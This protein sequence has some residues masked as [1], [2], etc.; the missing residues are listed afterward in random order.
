MKNHINAFSAPCS[1][2]GACVSACPK[3]A[4]KVSL[5]KEGVYTATVDESRCV[6]CGQ[7]KTVCMRLDTSSCLPLSSGTIVAAQSSNA[8]TVKKCT[9][10]GIAYE[11]SKYAFKNGMGILG[12]IYDY[13]TS[14]AVSCI[15]KTEE[16]IERFRGSKYIQSYTADAFR[17][18]LAEMK[19]DSTR[20]YLA[21][22][23]PCQIYGLAKLLE[24]HHMR[25]RAILVDLFCH[26]VPS[27]RVWDQYL[28]SLKAQLGTNRLTEVVFRDKSIGWH[29]FVIK[30]QSDKGEYKEASE[31]DLFY[32]AFFDNVLFSEACFDCAVRKAVSKADLRL[33]DYWGK[34]YQH[35]EDGISAVLLCT[36]RGKAFLEQIKDQ[37][38]C[39][40]AGSVD[41][42]MASQSVHIY[43]TKTYRQNA[44]F[45]LQQGKSL[46]KTIESYRKLFPAPK[47]VKLFVKESTAKL[48][49]GM[50]ATIRKIYKKL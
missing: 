33:G 31:G 2:C 46:Q 36:E 22:G 16:D 32:H 1:G 26:G 15:A 9:S 3:E 27:Y 28:E 45:D 21:F 50:R 47:R 4:I 34:R 14:R 5:D 43:A 41:E 42:V 19:N 44:F 11:M 13:E 29:N 39:F 35:R 38:I 48:P 25:D 40:E 23:T 20:K 7:C 18:M 30:L 10:G 8:A 17:E 37:L 6:D 12:V 49:D 24:K